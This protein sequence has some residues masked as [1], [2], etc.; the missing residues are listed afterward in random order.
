MGLSLSQTFS[1]YPVTIVTRGISSCSL[2]TRANSCISIEIF[3]IFVVPRI[4]IELDLSNP[5]LMTLPRLRIECKYCRAKSC[6]FHYD[7]SFGPVTVGTIAIV[8][9]F[10][11]AK[12]KCCSHRDNHEARSFWF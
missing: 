11:E 12:S 5:T 8:G 10:D 4:P 6:G 2:N 3:V 9:R 7:T 1:S